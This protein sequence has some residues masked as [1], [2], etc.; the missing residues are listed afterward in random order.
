MALCLLLAVLDARAETDA[1][2]GS[3]KT[4][5]IVRTESPPLIDGKLDDSVWQ[6]AEVITDFHQIR[7]GDGTPPSERTEVYLLYDDDAFYIGARMYDSEPRLIAAPT[8]RHGQGLGPDDRL[9]VILDPFNTGRSGYRFETN[10]NGVRHDALY[11]N[12]SSFQSD[13][14]VIW[15][16]AAQI[17]ETGWVAE[18]AIPFKTLPFDPSIDTWGF[19]FGRGIRRRGEEMAWVSRNRSYNPSILGLVTGLTGMDQGVGLDIVPSLAVRRQK[20]FLTGNGGTDSTTSPSL[21]LFYRLTPSLNGALTINTDFSAT[22]VDTRQVNLTR[23]NLFF[24][25]KRDFFLT[26][27]DLFEFGRIS[28][29]GA[30]DSNEATSRPSRENARPFFS[31]R[32]GLSA[33]GTPVDI[34]YGGKVSGRVGRFSIGS[35]AIRQDEFGLAGQ[36]DFVE[37]KDLFVGRV[38]ANV[39]D[40]SAVGIVVT[41][42]DPRSSGDNSVVGADFRFLNTRLA[43]GR[44]LEADAWYQQSD[45][46]GLDGDDA[47]FGFGVSMPNTAGLRAGFQI[48]EIERNFNPALGFISRSDVRDTAFDVGYTRFFSGGKL[49]RLNVGLDAQRF[50]LLDGGRQS[51]QMV[52]KLIDVETHTRDGLRLRY[53]TNEEFV[54]APFNVYFDS[55][56]PARNVVIGAGTYSFDEASIRLGTGN[57]RALSGNITYLVGDFYNGERTNVSGQFSWKPSRHFTLSLDYDFNDV[58]L[59]QGRFVTRLAGLSTQ[60]M[61]S[62]N[63]A[64]ITLM[65]YDN[66]SEVLG[67][68]TRLHWIPKAGQEGFIVLNH[69]L[70]DFDKNSSFHSA[71]ADLNVKFKYTFRF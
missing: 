26:D 37:R 13:W 25:E 64:W 46:P 71:A 8:G 23:F 50:D 36:P 47:A 16:T 3:R 45:T 60:V 57:Q 43:G 67:V 33:E 65:Q 58:E 48:K 62:T 55:S 4:V 38:T 42:G 11:T 66:I 15:D 2:P 20:A 41:D 12:V 9:V 52:L 63:L 44:V 69:N 68:N 56:D 59:P 49:Q 27:A 19:N 22:E 61:F 32:I 39:L 18:I 7:P 6:Q 70:Q 31:R 34:D 40:E 29:S 21:D 1:D 35:L 30:N 14:T 28:G 17:D 51:E 54:E 5:R 10:A 53:I 24:P